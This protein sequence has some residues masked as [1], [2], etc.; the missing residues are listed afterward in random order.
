MTEFI[1]E[2][3]RS[4][5]F[6]CEGLLNHSSCVAKKYYENDNYKLLEILKILDKLNHLDTKLAMKVEFFNITP[7]Q[8]EESRSELIIV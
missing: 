1:G 2:G 8:G 3:S 6:L 7:I 4:E 5:V